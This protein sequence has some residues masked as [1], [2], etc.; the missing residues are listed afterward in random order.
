MTSDG[1]VTKEVTARSS[2]SEK[3][4]AVYGAAGHT[5]RFVTAE[6]VRRGISPLLCG[7][8]ERKLD[9]VAKS[10][11][12]SEVR[13]AKLDDPAS[14]NRAL[15]GALAVI[16]CAG[17]Y[18]DTAPQVI[19]AAIRG[20]IHYLDLTAEQASAAAT[21]ENFAGASEAVGVVVAPA[22]A[23]Y[24][25]L[26]DLLSTVAVGDWSRVDEVR[27]AIALDSW[28]PTLGTR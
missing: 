28:H 4:V 8:D 17:P 15:D 26:A 13:V 22:M 20:R 10:T 5:G 9:D 11:P 16:N 2:K 21:F 18:L 25:G 14:L 3:V 1:A 23:F 27:I 7:R 12:G 19:E 6:L 24:G